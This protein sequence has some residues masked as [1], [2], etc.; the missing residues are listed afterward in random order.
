MLSMQ[1]IRVGEPMGLY[2]RGGAHLCVH[3]GMGPVG[4]VPVRLGS[5]LEIALLTLRRV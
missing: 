1:A 4:P 2:E 5:P 3:R